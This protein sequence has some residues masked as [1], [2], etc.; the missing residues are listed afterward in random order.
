MIPSISLIFAVCGKTVRSYNLASSKNTRLLPEQWRTAEG[1]N[2]LAGDGEALGS[3]YREGGLVAKVRG[4]WGRS[5]RS[6]GTRRRQGQNRNNSKFCIQ[7]TK[8]NFLLSLGL[9][10][11]TDEY[12]FC[13]VFRDLQLSIQALFHLSNGL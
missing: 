9:K 4:C 10:R 3:I 2:G 8:L 11:K 12:H 1:E 13:L 5:I 6:R 7:F